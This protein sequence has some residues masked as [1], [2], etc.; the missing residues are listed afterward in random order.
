MK[1]NEL[2]IEL[3]K[4]RNKRDHK[5]NLVYKLACELNEDLSLTDLNR[6]ITN[7]NTCTQQLSNLQTR[8]LDIIDELLKET[9]SELHQRSGPVETAE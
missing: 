9:M 8:F 2:N 5:R 7:L 1:L 6:V 4:V 3:N